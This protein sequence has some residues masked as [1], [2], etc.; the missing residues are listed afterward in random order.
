MRKG[1]AQQMELYYHPVETAVIPTK[2]RDQTVALFGALKELYVNDTF[3]DEILAII[4]SHLP[5]KLNTGRRGLSLWQVFVLAQLRL[6]L[7]ISYDRLEY[8][9]NHDELLRHILGI[10]GLANVEKIQWNYQRIYDNVGIL[11]DVAVRDLNGI[12][13]KMGHQVFKKKKRNPCA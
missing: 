12:I 8:M 1:F 9:T 7:D 10:R 3:R 13:V 11:T 2:C 6:C 4:Q 5:K